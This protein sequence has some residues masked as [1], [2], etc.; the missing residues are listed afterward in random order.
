MS[1]GIS[2]ALSLL[3]TPLVMRIAGAIGAMDMPNERKIHTRPVPRLGGVAVWGS[4]FFTIV[5]L[6]LFGP[7]PISWSKSLSMNGALLCSAFV[8]VVSIGIWDDIH[9]LPPG[10]KFMVQ[11]AAASLCYLGGFRIATITNPFNMGS[12]TLGWLDFPITVIWIIGVTN[13]FNL[14]DGLDGLATGVAA[15]ATM[16]IFSILML[17]GNEPAALL[18]LIFTGALLGFLRYNFN[19]A[20]IFL[21]DSGSLMIGLALALLSIK[22]STKGST[23][24]AILVPLLA[25]GL[26]IMDT[27]I[28][29]L[30]RLLDSLMPGRKPEKL[31]SKVHAMFL[32]DRK[33]IHHRL[34]TLGFSHKNTVLTLYLVACA[35]GLGALIITISNSIGATMIIIAATLAMIS[36]VRHLQYKEMAILRNGILLPIYEWPG[37]KSALIHGFM[38][39]AFIAL[40]FSGSF[41]LMLGGEFDHEVRARLLFNLPVVCVIQII[42][43]TLSGS[44][45][46]AGNAT[47]VDDLLRIVRSVGVSVACTAAVFILFVNDAS[48]HHAI[49]FVSDFY[50]LV[51]LMIA[52]RISY[53]VLTYFFKR[54]TKEGKNVLIYGA[55]SRGVLTLHQ[56]LDDERLQLKPI[57]FLDEHPLLQGKWI[58]GYKVLGGHWK[59]PRLLN[60]Y[61]VAEILLSGDDLREE[62]VRRVTEFGKRN[63]VTITRMRVNLEEITSIRSSNKSPRGAHILHQNGG[64]VSTETEGVPTEMPNGFSDGLWEMEDEA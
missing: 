15:I 36:G 51:S 48:L 12:F 57:G 28:A 8:L 6:S 5:L 1:F 27:L 2:L 22:S 56:I 30:R 21:G 9:Q 41:A 7:S 23:T 47:S 4:V 14:I 25:L 60:R 45:R 40:A 31:L 55:N 19:P 46:G 29:M 18:A 13:S 34:V 53:H 26:P 54:E 58:N 59:L 49:F 35:F 43:L 38:D 61:H 39:L 63:G 10:P 64:G 62:V 20:R 32:P 42:A 17:K 24:V 44:Y 37:F 16:T 52:S 11:L 33:H 50:L 3:L